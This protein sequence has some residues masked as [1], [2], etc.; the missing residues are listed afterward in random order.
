METVNAN[1]S[2]LK[3]KKKHHRKAKKHHKKSHAQ[4]QTA[5][6]ELSGAKVVPKAPAEAQT[7]A[8]MVSERVATNKEIKQRTYKAAKAEEDLAAAKAAAKAA[9]EAADSAGKAE[10]AAQKAKVDAVESAKAEEAKL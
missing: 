7:E 9:E 1:V 10:D 8:S 4:V 5:D 6:D 2:T 3:S